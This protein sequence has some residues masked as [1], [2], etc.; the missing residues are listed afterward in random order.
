M[1]WNNVNPSY[2]HDDLRSMSA[3]KAVILML[4]LLYTH[5]V[6]EGVFDYK[7]GKRYHIHM[8]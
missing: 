6:I 4:I 1:I 7:I 3:I 8:I 5:D 2:H